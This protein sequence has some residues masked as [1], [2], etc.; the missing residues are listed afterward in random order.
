MNTSN[1][2]VDKYV[3]KNGTKNEYYD[4][5]GGVKLPVAGHLKVYEKETGNFFGTLPVIETMSD[6]K[7]Q[8][9]CLNDRLEHPEYYE[10]DEDVP[11]TIKRLK[12]WLAEHSP[13]K[14]TR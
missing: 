11:A 7:W 12:K 9:M 5:G 4:V 2:V 14:E 1:L 8:L 3:E 13:D 6:Y 10:K